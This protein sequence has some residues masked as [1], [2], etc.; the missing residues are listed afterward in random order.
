MSAPPAPSVRLG[1]PRQIVLS[2][3]VRGAGFNCGIPCIGKTELSAPGA[4]RG[5][6]GSRIVVPPL[7]C[8]AVTGG[9]TYGFLHPEP[10]GDVPEIM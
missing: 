9:D 5:W 1:L 10:D 7:H 4:D 3:K 8:R 2:C 6:N